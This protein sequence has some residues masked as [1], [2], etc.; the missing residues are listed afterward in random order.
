MER[1]IGM[2][3]TL[4]FMAIAVPIDNVICWLSGWYTAKRKFGGNE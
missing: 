1:G 4:I 2:R 3:Q